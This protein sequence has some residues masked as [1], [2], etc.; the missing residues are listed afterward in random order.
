MRPPRTTP[1]P[2][3]T[4]FQK[5]TQERI[6]TDY[7]GWARKVHGN[8]MTVGEPDIDACIRGRA[9]KLELKQPGKRPTAL[10]MAK[11]RTWAAAGALSGWAVTMV[12]V[13]ALLE[14]VDDPTW[15]NPQ[16]AERPAA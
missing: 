7:G 4:A 2:N 14:H 13:D 16:L 6:R 11:L 15:V 8:A 9:V 10:Q 3:E 5:A 1:Y 12:E